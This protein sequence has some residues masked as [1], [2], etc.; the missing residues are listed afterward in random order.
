MISVNPYSLTSLL[1]PLLFSLITT[2]TSEELS[3]SDFITTWETTSNNEMITIPTT[4]P[5][6]NY[7]VDW[8]DGTMTTGHNGNTSHSYSSPGNYQ[9]TISG[10]FPR[11]FFNGTGDADNILSVDQWGTGIWISMEC[12]FKGCWKLDILASDI[13]ILN[14]GTSFKGMFAGT[15]M[16]NSDLSN[17]DVSNVVDMSE[18]FSYCS[19]NQNI[20]SWDVSNV[21]NMSSMFNSNIE[22]D[23][24]LNNWDVSMVTD[25]SLMFASAL[26]FNQNL[27]SWDVSQVTDMTRM[28][29]FA[30]YFNKALYNWDVS[31]VVNIKSMFDGAENFNGNISSWN[32]AS[33]T[34]L[35]EMF[36]NS[37]FNRNINSWDVSNVTSM[38]HMFIGASNFNMP[39]SN[40]DVSNVTDMTRMFGFSGFNQDIGNWDVSNVTSMYEMFEQSAF[41]QD[42]SDWN[43]QSVNSFF[44]FLNNSGFSTENYD[45]LLSEWSELI[46]QNNL[47]FGAM[48]IQY[49]AGE[50]GRNDLINNHLWNITDA[51]KAGTISIPNTFTNANNNNLW[52]DNA[53]WSLGVVPNEIHAALIPS[54][55]NAELLNGQVGKCFTIEVEDGANFLVELGADFRTTGP[56]NY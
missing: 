53:N 37:G 28:F 7:T 12:A 16:F 30:Y 50:D 47:D 10:S 51:G 29:Q 18:M 31:N 55:L 23:M 40:W 56:C 1:L 41:D 6:Y 24:P 33:A 45:L 15:G 34:E 2:T 4:G 5:G 3:T 26:K 36:S 43:V 19:F 54:P 9:I 38:Y 21:T 32:L 46:V 11:I 25:M 17:W 13:P 14:T 49:C 52:D 22:F 35:D 48:G 27:N 42:I 44:G 39:L 20:N 8:G